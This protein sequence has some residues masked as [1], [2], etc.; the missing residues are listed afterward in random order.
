MEIRGNLDEIQKN[1]SLFRDVFPNGDILILV[2]SFLI[3]S[4]IH[5]TILDLL[6]NGQ[7]V[8]Q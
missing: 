8:G 6:N 2:L 1:S 3:A 7:F 4:L 5:R